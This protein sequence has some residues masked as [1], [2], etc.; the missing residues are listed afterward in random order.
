MYLYK[1]GVFF[2]LS[3][4]GGGVR[5]FFFAFVIFYPRRRIA[6]LASSRSLS[7]EKEHKEFKQCYCLLFQFNNSQPIDK[8]IDSVQLGVSEK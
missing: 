5:F 6:L 7:G 1:L 2:C 3:M 4:K 8:V